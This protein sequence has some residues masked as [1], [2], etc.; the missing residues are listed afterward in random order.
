[1]LDKMIVALS[2][3]EEEEEEYRLSLQDLPQGRN[4]TTGY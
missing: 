2:P 1:M 4:E 3:E